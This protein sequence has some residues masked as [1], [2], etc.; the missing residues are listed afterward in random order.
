[1]TTILTNADGSI[2]ADSGG[3]PSF[4]PVS[5][6]ELN[7][8][9]CTC[10]HCATGTTP[11]TVTI[12]L[13]DT[14]L[15]PLNGPAVV[16]ARDWA[17]GPCAWVGAT[18]IGG[19]SYLYHFAWLAESSTW[20]VAIQS[21]TGGYPDALRWESNPL[22]LSWF[23]CVSGGSVGYDPSFGGSGTAAV[24]PTPYLLP[25]FVADREAKCQACGR[26]DTHG[27]C[28]FRPDCTRCYRKL[29]GAMCPAPIPLWRPIRG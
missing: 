13:A 27:V 25:A 10:P 24:V 16:A 1:M 20:F 7:K 28:R 5:Q 2:G 17:N 12:T 18:V 23:D 15:G 14:E 6:E 3:S 22:T 8:C 11:Q 21:V 26:L 29:P 4:G 19:N 9:C